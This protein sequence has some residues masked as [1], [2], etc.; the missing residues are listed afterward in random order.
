MTN[1]YDRNG[2][3]DLQMQADS[4][5][6][7]FAYT[8]DALGR[9]EQVNLPDP[10]GHVRRVTYDPAVGYLLINTAAYATSLAR[11]TTLTRNTS[12]LVT[13]VNGLGRH[14]DYAYD[15][16]RNVTSV[17]RRE[18]LR[19]VVMYS[20]FLAA[21]TAVEMG[22]VAALVAMEAVLVLRGLVATAEE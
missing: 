12:N 21:G 11:T 9:V 13:R 15:A 8:L 6:F 19:G 16:A 14:T 22:A 7:A 2:R 3:V 10:R 4:T 1:H 17:T 5:T 20:H 18:L